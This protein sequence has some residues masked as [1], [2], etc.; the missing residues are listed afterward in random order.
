MQGYRSKTEDLSSVIQSFV[1]QTD[2]FLAFQKLRFERFETWVTID[3]LA[4]H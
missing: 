3:Y 4:G 1:M 2:I